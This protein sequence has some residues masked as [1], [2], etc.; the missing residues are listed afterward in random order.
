M[1][2]IPYIERH[3]LYAA[4]IQYPPGCAASAYNPL[5]L[6]VIRGRKVRVAWED[7]DLVITLALFDFGAV[8]TDGVIERDHRGDRTEAW[9]I[10]GTLMTQAWAERNIPRPPEKTL[11]EQLAGMDRPDGKAA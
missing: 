11:F 6:P 2:E 4:A 8:R 10:A 7:V 5:G 1:D 3:D 9:W